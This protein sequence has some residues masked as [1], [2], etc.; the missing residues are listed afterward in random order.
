MGPADQTI[1]SLSVN[2]SSDSATLSVPRLRD[3]RS[4]WADYLPRIERVLG[5]K[6]LWRHVEGTAIQPKPYAL[7][8]GVLTLASGKP[9]TEEQV[10][11]REMKII[12]YDKQEYLAQHV[13]L[14]TTSACLGSKIKSL[15]SAKEMWEVVKTDATTKS[16]LFILD[17]EDQ[18]SSMRLADNED[19][20][21]HLSKMKQ[22]F[23]LMLQHHENLIKMGSSLSDTRFNAIIMSSLPEF[24]QPTLQTITAAEKTSALA[25]GTSS[26]KMKTADLITFLIEKA[27]HHVITDERAKNSELALAAQAKKARKKRST[28]SKGKEKAKG[29][30]ADATCDNCHKPGH[31]GADCWSKGGGK[32]G[33]G[34]RQKKKRSDKAEKADETVMS[35]APL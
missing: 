31:K 26:R 4:N 30:D 13:I 21:I 15:K 32:E 11:S 5:S 3:D 6:G 9:A 33:Q 20:K 12:E 14:S 1:T 19:P 28:C 7:V 8:D 18:L 25:D 34:P 17:A 23:Q 24:Y 16:T 27:Q 2:S 10:E 22:H 35:R 29:T